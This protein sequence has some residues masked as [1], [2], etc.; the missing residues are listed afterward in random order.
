MKFWLNGFHFYQ[1]FIPLTGSSL[2]L[3]N[4]KSVYGLMSRW[5]ARTELTRASQQQRRTQTRNVGQFCGGTCVS[6]MVCVLKLVFLRCGFVNPHVPFISK[7]TQLALKRLKIIISLNKWMPDVYR[8][9][10][11]LGGFN[12]SNQLSI[13]AISALPSP[14]SLSLSLSL[15]LLS[16]TEN[17][18]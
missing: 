6:R 10:L 14:F 9:L 4:N 3:S 1:W 11:R 13:A 12:V 15:S 8:F 18:S 2:S 5:G 17:Q 7:H 16:V